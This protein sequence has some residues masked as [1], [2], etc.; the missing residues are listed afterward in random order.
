MLHQ[1]AV[2]QSIRWLA[3]ANPSTFNKTTSLARLAPPAAIAT[4][5]HIQIRQAATQPTSPSDAYSIL[6][7][8]RLHRPVSPHLKIYR[9]QITWIL[10]ALNRITGS[11]LS[12]GFYIFGAAYLVSPL[13]GWHLDTASLAAAF[14]SWPWAA[15]LAAKMAA[16]FPFTFHAWNGIRHLTWDVGAALN[17]QQVIRTGW[18]VVGFTVVS[19]LALALL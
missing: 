11:V 18:V 8:Q 2:Q 12:G 7:S 13:F 14:A 4:G 3:V 19:S 6:A 1:R 17:N 9:P 5:R 10:S 15:Q 16:A